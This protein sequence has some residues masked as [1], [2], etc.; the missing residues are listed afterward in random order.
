MGLSH[1]QEKEKFWRRQLTLWEGSGSTQVEYCRENGLSPH[2]FLY[3]RRKFAD[4]GRGQK[5]SRELVMSSF[6]R[7]EIL[8]SERCDRVLPEAKWLAELIMH[9]QAGV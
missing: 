8:P 9:L 5:T 4:K 7:V 2:V 3:W 6:A 1:N